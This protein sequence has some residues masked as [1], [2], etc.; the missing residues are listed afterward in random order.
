MF[1]LFLFFCLAIKYIMTGLTIE[2]MFEDGRG[3]INM[4]PDYLQGEYPHS[5][6]LLL[7]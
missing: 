6:M 1:L 3:F 4:G 5:S 7:G 2:A